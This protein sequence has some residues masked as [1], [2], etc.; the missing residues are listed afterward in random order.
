MP[1]KREFKKYVDALGSSVIE[2]MTIAYYNIEGADRE[3]IAEAVTK[4]LCAV[5]KAKNAANHFMGK[6][7]RQFADHQAYAKAKRAYFKEL[8]GKI[9]DE[10][11][12]DVNEAL[13]KFNAALPESAKAAQKE[14]V[15]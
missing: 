10:F 13:K 1:N 15:K 9:T 14:A 4:T 2:Q 3:A 11:N 12:A 6:G 5:G 8:F 7:M